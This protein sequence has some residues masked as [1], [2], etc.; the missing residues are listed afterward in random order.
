MIDNEKYRDVSSRIAEQISR[1]DSSLY[2]MMGIM[3][4]ISDQAE[5]TDAISEGIDRIVSYII[6]LNGS[7]RTLR[8]EIEALR[9]TVNSTIPLHEDDDLDIMAD[10]VDF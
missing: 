3:E 9:E 10:G 6:T 1:Q 4:L 2:P 5:S 7:I 8:A